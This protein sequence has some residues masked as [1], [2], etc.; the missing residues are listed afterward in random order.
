[1]F[2]SLFRFGRSTPAVK[3]RASTAARVEILEDR[4]M[5]AMGD[6]ASFIQP[7]YIPDFIDPNQQILVIEGTTGVDKFELR[8]KSGGKVE[9]RLNGEK[10]GTF[11]AGFRTLLN[12]GGESD[13]VRVKGKINNL[14]IQ[15]SGGFDDI[16]GGSGNDIILGYFGDDKLNG[17]KGRDIVIGGEGSD[18]VKGDVGE[19]ILTGGSTD[20]DFLDGTGEWN[21]IP[22]IMIQSEWSRT[23]VTYSNRVLSV[24]GLA[25]GWN[26]VYKLDASTVASGAIPPDA[27]N[28]GGKQDLF[29]I[30]RDPAID[31]KQDTIKNRKSNE[32]VVLITYET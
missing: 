14:I 3:L 27:L 7:Y 26:D 25:T 5:F 13:K 22:F 28:G 6:N 1:M 17:K 12:T 9:V 21:Y 10:K 18:S 2:S 29:F 20:W 4:K 15:G 31:G 11:V 8:N 23:D 24:Q 19:D 30:S 32:V 16:Q